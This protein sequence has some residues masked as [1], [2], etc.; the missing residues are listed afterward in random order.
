[1][2]INTTAPNPTDQNPANWLDAIRNR[3][4]AA[5]PGTWTVQAA[6]LNGH[7]LTRCVGTN[8]LASDDDCIAELDVREDGSDAANADFIAH[9]PTDIDQL[10]AHIDQLTHRLAAAEAA[11]PGITHL[12][13]GQPVELTIY[14]TEHDTIPCGL[15]TNRAAA[16]ACGSDLSTRDDDRIEVTH[17]WIPEHGGDDAAEDL[18]LFGPGGED[19][20]TI[21]NYSIV[22]LTLH[23]AYDPQS[24]EDES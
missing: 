23:A 5:S 22:P 4:N 21:T 14:R 19:D 6:T 8:D 10:L 16:R 12:V 11:F 9:A 15:F 7:V 13:P 20:E 24:W 18:S 2:T 1:M 3:R 17:A